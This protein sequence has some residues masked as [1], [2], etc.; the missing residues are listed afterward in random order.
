MSNNILPF[1]EC[2]CGGRVTKPGNRFIWGHNNSNNGKT[3]KKETI[4]KWRVSYKKTCEIKRKN[5][6]KPE[7]KLCECKCGG[8]ASPG[9]RFISGHNTRVDNPM[10]RPEVRKKHKKSMEIGKKHKKSMEIVM[11]DPIVR[12]NISDGL[13]GNHNPTEWLKTPEGKKQR[14]DLGKRMWK[15]PE[16]RKKTSKAISKG[17]TGKRT[18]PGTEYKPGHPPNTPNSE[19][20]TELGHVVRSKV[21]KKVCIKLKQ[22]G[23]QYIYEEGYSIKNSKKIYPD[24]TVKN[25]NI[26]IEIKGAEYW[27]GK[28]FRE[29]IIE[30]RNL[31]PTYKYIL[32]SHFVDNIETFCDFH[33]DLKMFLTNMDNEVERLQSY[34]VSCGVQ[35]EE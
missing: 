1:C 28:R 13:K 32:I 23:L 8:Y 35:L 24:L 26:V 20:S 3:R 15:D 31:H 19:F 6:P 11:K 18:S 14:S 30:F 21:E 5:R 17:K 16:Y 27:M 4:E 29:R 33:I 34:L 9:R 2:G 10:D 25:K 7:Q 22:I 12:K